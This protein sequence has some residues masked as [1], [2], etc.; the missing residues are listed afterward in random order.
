[1]NSWVL[2]D[3]TDEDRDIIDVHASKIDRRANGKPF[4]LGIVETRNWGSGTSEIVI[5]WHDN[6]DGTGKFGWNTK[7]THFNK[8]R[9][10]CDI[11]QVKDVGELL[12]KSLEFRKLTTKLGALL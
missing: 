6:G 3:V 1:M 10:Y 4:S 12:S 5:Y 11:P 2:I 7:R 9:E 8:N